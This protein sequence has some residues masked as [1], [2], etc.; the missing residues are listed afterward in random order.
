MTDLRSED[1]DVEPAVR[2]SDFRT[3]PFDTLVGLELNSFRDKD[4]V[5]L[6]DMIQLW[7]IDASWLEA[8]PN[9]FLSRLEMLLD[10]PKG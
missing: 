10:D 4:R 5:H 7:L 8:P 2:M 6:R 1:V 3:V 9:A